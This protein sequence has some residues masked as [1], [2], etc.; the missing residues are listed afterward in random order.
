[1]LAEFL[2]LAEV[3]GLEKRKKHEGDGDSLVNALVSEQRPF[4]EMHSTSR[5]LSLSVREPGISA[6]LFLFLLGFGDDVDGP[7]E[8]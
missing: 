3:R 6:R 1:M 7:S 5:V 4:E 2:F 8:K